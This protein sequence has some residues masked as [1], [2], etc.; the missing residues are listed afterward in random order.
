MAQEWMVD[1]VSSGYDIVIYGA[2]TVARRIYELL[3]RYNA[4][5]KIKCFVVE[6]IDENVAAIKN[7]KVVQYKAANYT[8]AVCIIALAKLAERYCVNDKLQKMG[9]A[10]EKILLLNDKL[11][12]A[13]RELEKENV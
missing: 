8:K 13:L 10:E 9:I 12:R 3:K 7:I 2:G 5:E 1:I 11:Y 6:D 4:I